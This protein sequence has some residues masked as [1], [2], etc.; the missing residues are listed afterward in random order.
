MKRIIVDGKATKEFASNEEKMVIALMSFKLLPVR[1]EA[2]GMICTY[3]F[4]YEKVIDIANRISCGDIND[5]N[6]SLVD[7][8]A[9]QNIWRIN[10]SRARLGRDEKA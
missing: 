4:E 3:F 8:W 7:L 9:A 5:L 1:I 2:D 10:L 6:V